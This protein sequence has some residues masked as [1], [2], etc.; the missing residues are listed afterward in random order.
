MTRVACDS[1]TGPGAWWPSGLRWL[2][3]ATGRYRPGS[4]P[5]A[6]TSLRNFG[7]CVYPA[8]PVS[9]GKGRGSKR[10]YQS[11]LECAPPT[12]N[13]RPS[14]TDTHCQWH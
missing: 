8:L 12:L 1:V 14:D 11:A 7:N 5:A 9:F 6:A 2:G 10:S 13:P 3:L 4:N